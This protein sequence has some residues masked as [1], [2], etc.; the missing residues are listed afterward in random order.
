MGVF[1]SRVKRRSLLCQPDGRSYGMAV[2]WLAQR[3][4]FGEA[5][6][7]INE[8]RMPDQHGVENG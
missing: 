4:A 3:I 6:C 2:Y 7:R 5:R 1:I 8:I